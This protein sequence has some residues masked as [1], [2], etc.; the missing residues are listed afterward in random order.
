LNDKKNTSIAPR[1]AVAVLISVGFL[2][3]VLKRINWREFVN[4]GNA[5]DYGMIAAGFGALFLANVVRAL[6]FR[7][8]DPLRQKFGSWWV[9]GQA[10]NLMTATFPGGTGEVATAYLLKRFY[11]FDWLSGIKILVVTRV[12]DLA[13]LTGLFLSSALI[14][15]RVHNLTISA[16]VVAAVLFVLS[17]IMLIPP[18]QRLFVE[19]LRRLYPKRAWFSAKVFGLAQ[20]ISEGA[21]FRGAMAS[22]VS[23][24]YTITMQLL[25]ICSIY[26]VL[27]GLG[28]DL[29]FFET[30][31]C[32]GIYVLFQLVPVQGFAGLGT[33]AAWWAIALS[34]AGY[35]GGNT[36]ALGLALYATFYVFIAMLCLLAVVYWFAMTRLVRIRSDQLS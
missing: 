26:L 13:V 18:F 17:V 10:Y 4:F 14:V 11:N 35:T 25:A 22:F 29:T 21:R 1:V 19:G 7:H 34:L 32:F 5:A 3:F 16:I 2:F 9:M 15:R 20:R 33:Q 23:G 28:V 31:F 27:L 36:V 24:A 12:M 8:L 6:R 30:I